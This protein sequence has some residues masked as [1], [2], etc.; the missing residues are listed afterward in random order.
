MTSFK[1]YYNLSEAALSNNTFNR[2]YSKVIKKL[3]NGKKVYLGKIKR[4]TRFIQL[5][6]TKHKKLI[7]RLKTVSTVEE[8]NTAFANSDDLSLSKIKWTSLFKGDF[9]NS[10][11]SKKPTNKGNAFEFIF[12]EKIKTDESVQ[13]TLAKYFNVSVDIIKNCK[14]KLVGEQNNKRPLTFNGNTITCGNIGT[15]FNIGNLVSDITLIND[16]DEYYISCKYGNTTKFVNSGIRTVFPKDWFIGNAELPKKGKALLDMLCLDANMFRNVFNNYST[17]KTNKKSKLT[18]E[19]V[20]ITDKLKTNKA[21]ETFMKSVIGYGYIIAHADSKY[22]IHYIDLLKETKLNKFLRG[23]DKA[24]VL[25]PLDGSTKRVD[26]TIEYE[27]ITFNLNMRAKDGGI[28]PTHI[29][30]DYI[31]KS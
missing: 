27:Y 29:M 24:T 7:D 9:S 30:A 6:K 20:D 5:D 12:A 1:T 23:L 19:Y 18:K 16:N 25:Y 31:F 13:K 10:G 21:F 8:F 2:Y 15:N 22:N 26:I 28:Y 4:K 3:I 17:D 11:T 14:V